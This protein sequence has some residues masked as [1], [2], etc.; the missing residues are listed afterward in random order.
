MVKK[1]EC[2]FEFAVGDVFV[3]HAFSRG[4]VTDVDV[5][6]KRVVIVFDSG[7]FVL[8]GRFFDV[9]KVLINSEYTKVTW[10]EE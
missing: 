3:N 2:V 7:N 5:E 4:V 1:V 10:N 8:S 6:A 9:T